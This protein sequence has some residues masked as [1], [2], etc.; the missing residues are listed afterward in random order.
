MTAAVDALMLVID[1]YRFMMLLAG[2]LMGLVLGIIPGVGGLVGMALLLPFTFTMDPYTAFA[3]LLGITAVTGTSDTIPAVLFGVP[4]TSG[5]QA[6]ILDGHAM[7]KK[8]EAGRALSAAYMSSLIGGLIGA[9]VLALAVPLLRPL[10]LHFGS[11]ELLALS[12][13]G[14]SMVAVLS[15]NAPLRGLAAAGLGIMLAMVGEDPQTSTMRWTLDSLYLWE[16][17]PLV[18][19]VLGVFAL[20]EVADMAIKRGSISSDSK[21]DAKGGMVLG[22]KDTFKNSWLVLRCGGFGAAIGAVPGL[23]SSV[24]DWLNYGHALQTVKGADKTFGTGD[25]RGV[26]APESANNAITAGALVPT[27]AFGVPGSASMAILLG[28]FLMHGLVPGPDMLTVNL[29]VTYTLIWSV[30]IANILGAGICFLLSGQLAKVA[31]LRYTLILPVALVVIYIGSFQASRDWGDL[32][33]LLIFGILGWAMKQLKWPRPPLILGFVL[34]GLI[35]RY[36]FISI[37]SYGI[38]WLSH[39][40]VVGLLLLAF[41]SIL[42]PFLKEM[43]IQGGLRNM[44]LSFGEPTFRPADIF[45]IFFIGIIGLMLLQAMDWSFA[46]KIGP[47]VVGSFTLGVAIISFICQV[48]RRLSLNRAASP[49]VKVQVSIKQKMHMD[50][51]ADHSELPVGEVM[52]RAA[53]FFGWLVAFMTSMAVIGVILTIPLFVVLYMRLEGKEPWARTLLQA[54]VL[55]LFVYG[56]FDQLLNL[57]WPETYLGTYFPYLRFIP[58]L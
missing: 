50:T 35:E 58:S 55:T 8:G 54:T 15:G 51:S 20:P 14:I 13:F 47:M 24:V 33:T 22:V 4:G 46:P 2:V 11:P 42:R 10:V 32:Y 23:G 41:L 6:T 31:L 12:I 40:I 21:Y 9:A 29:D 18:P 7:A 27:V 52:R 34:G 49:G 56:V 25:V 43:R 45:Y 44:I 48:F 26:I 38:S 37:N 36:M 30:A 17:L 53:V 5:A 19:M 16:G 28:A 1:P 39:P 57:P 3:V